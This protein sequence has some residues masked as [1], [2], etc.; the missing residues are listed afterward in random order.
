[1]LSVVVLRDEDFPPAFGGDNND[2]HGFVQDPL[3]A[4]VF[5]RAI[6]SR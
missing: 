5:L 1:M 6:V 2:L 4:K 3:N